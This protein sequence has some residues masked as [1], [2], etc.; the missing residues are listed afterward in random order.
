MKEI[1]RHDQTRSFAKISKPRFVPI[2]Q[3]N[4]NALA[5]NSVNAKSA[6][7]TSR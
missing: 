5:S 3:M 7:N 2:R 1:A 6:K 4:I